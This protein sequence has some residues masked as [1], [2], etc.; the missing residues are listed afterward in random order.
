MGWIVRLL[1]DGDVAV[2][3]CRI[4]HGQTIA[5]QTS[6]LAYGQLRVAGQMPT[7]IVTSSADCGHDAY[8]SHPNQQYED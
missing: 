1:V 8:Y 4:G 2:A 3:S 6:C 7:G 5:P